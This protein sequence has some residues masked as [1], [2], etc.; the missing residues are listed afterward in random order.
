MKRLFIAAPI[1][2]ELKNR[3]KEI[4]QRTHLSIPWIPLENLH[5]TLLFLGDVEEERISL[6]QD[7]MRSIQFSAFE[8]MATHVDYAPNQ[9]MPNFSKREK[10]GA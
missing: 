2:R 8:A 3:I 10:F 7:A 9:N 4:E 5:L 1:S 6:I